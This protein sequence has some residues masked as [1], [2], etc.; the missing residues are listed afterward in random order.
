MLVFL[1]RTSC[2]MVWKCFFFF[3]GQFLGSLSNNIGDSFRLPQTLLRLFH[4]VQFVECWRIFLELNSKGLYESSGKEK[5]GRCLVFTSAVSRGSRATT[6]K[7]CIQQ[8]DHRTKLLFCQSNPL[9]FL[10]SSLPSLSSLLKLP[11]N[12]P[13]K[14]MKQRPCWWTQISSGTWI[15]LFSSH[16]KN[17]FSLKK[18]ADHVSESDLYCIIRLT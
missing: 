11:T 9:A 4:L 7:K 6:A 8:R 17:F 10:P 5:E 15:R 16:V 1:K 12:L 2:V 13:L 18:V 3:S 14:T